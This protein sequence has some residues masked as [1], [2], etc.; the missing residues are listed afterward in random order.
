MS[1]Q[2]TPLPSSNPWL[3]AIEPFDPSSSNLSWGEETLSPKNSMFFLTGCHHKPIT[4]GSDCRLVCGAS[5]LNPLLSPLPMECPC[6]PPNP[7]LYK[8]LTGLLLAVEV[9]AFRLILVGSLLHSPPPLFEP[10]C[11][12]SD[13]RASLV[14]CVGGPQMLACGRMRSNI[15]K[16]RFPM[17][18][19]TEMSHLWISLWTFRAIVKTSFMRLQPKKHN[20][21]TSEW[22]QL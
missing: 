7:A 11:T 16:I 4:R 21:I 9:D 13:L 1:A 22:W 2:K 10:S 18:F 19:P 14:I 20:Q 5:L 6:W 17:F 8:A 15:L 12:C 3:D